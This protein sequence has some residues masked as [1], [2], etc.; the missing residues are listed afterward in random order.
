MP[1]PQRPDPSTGAPASD[2]QATE[3][4]AEL[5][6]WT[7]YL[8]RQ[9]ALRAQDEVARALAP[10]GLRGPHYAVLAAIGAEPRSQATLAARLQTDRSTMV[11]VVDDLERL[12]LAERR[13]HRTDRRAHAVTLTPAGRDL[14][15][16]AHGALAAADDALLADTD[17]PDRAHL[18]RLL[19][20]LIAGYD[21]RRGPR[22]PKER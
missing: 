9:A 10:L 5:T 12:Q 14:L 4:P 16:R 7:T 19:V 6:Q 3:P 11:A 22:G 2:R 15:A 17:A 8:L 20:R 13:A 21:Q 18:R 1:D